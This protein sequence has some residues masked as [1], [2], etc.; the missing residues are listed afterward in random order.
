MIGPCFVVLTLS[1]G[2]VSGPPATRPHVRPASGPAAASSP[3]STGTSPARSA[4]TVSDAPGP[5]GAPPSLRSAD[6]SPLGWLYPVAG[7]RTSAV[8]SRF[9][10]SRDGG[11]R[12]H[13]GIDIRA[14]RGTPVLAPA[15]GRV[16]AS[17]RQSRGGN[18][19][20][21]LVE[22]GTEFVFAHLDSRGV[23]AGDRVGAGQTLGTVGNT[24]NARGTTPHLHFEVHRG[25][26][27]VDPY[28]LFVGGF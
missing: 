15:A 12:R 22:G 21:L 2:C 19:V 6:I 26:R 20:V 9:G 7:F 11:T 18:I 10:D 14:P 5:S 17:R 23:G 4:I 28:P 13:A 25:D 27:P 1:I 24:G 3:A 8:I 16:T